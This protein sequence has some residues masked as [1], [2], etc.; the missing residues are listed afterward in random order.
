MA[1]APQVAAVL[2]LVALVAV[3]SLPVLACVGIGRYL[4]QRRRARRARFRADLERDTIQTLYPTSDV[5]AGRVLASERSRRGQAPPLGAH[6]APPRPREP[7]AP[8]PPPPAARAASSAASRAR[9]SAM[10]QRTSAARASVSP[11]T[12]S[13][14]RLR[15]S[16][17]HRTL[18]RQDSGQAARRHP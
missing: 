14:A 18:P 15:S 7:R 8:R 16:I 10:S 5:G 6:R 17:A 4:R 2:K 12:A 3:L 1:H 13:S 11:Q 9:H